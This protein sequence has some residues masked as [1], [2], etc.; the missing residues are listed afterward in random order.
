MVVHAETDPQTS[1]L[2]D[3]L[4]ERSRSAEV[5]ELSLVELALAHVDASLSLPLHLSPAA[6]ASPR[7]LYLT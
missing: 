7:T 5:T 3:W 1:C 6:M 2:S 4:V